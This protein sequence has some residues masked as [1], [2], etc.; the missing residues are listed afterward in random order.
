MT[1][2]IGTLVKLHTNIFL[3]NITSNYFLKQKN[4]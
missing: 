3:I 1:D 4:S 2:A